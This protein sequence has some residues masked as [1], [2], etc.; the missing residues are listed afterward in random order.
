LDNH[1][2]F[3]LSNNDYS[4]ECKELE[5]KLLNEWDM[6]ID[7]ISKEIQQLRHGRLDFSQ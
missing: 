5:Q 6:V 2:S 4:E 3:D 7:D 1:H